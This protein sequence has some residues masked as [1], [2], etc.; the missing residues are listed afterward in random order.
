MRLWLEIKLR[1]PTIHTRPIMAS[2][3]EPRRP[4]EPRPLVQ[5]PPCQRLNRS[6]L[7]SKRCSRRTPTGSE[8]EL[9]QSLSG[10]C[11]FGDQ[12]ISKAKIALLIRKVGEQWRNKCNVIF[13]LSL[14]SLL[15][16]TFI[17]LRCTVSSGSTFV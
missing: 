16:V 6:P 4:L 2:Y 8:H 13:I 17:T 7:I 12:R 15:S 14:L 9:L 3:P 11:K 1:P 5:R 10:P